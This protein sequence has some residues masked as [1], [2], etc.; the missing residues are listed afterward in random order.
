[1]AFMKLVR[2]LFPLVFALP[3]FAGTAFAPDAPAAADW[4]EIL[5]NRLP[6]LGH[7]NWIVIADS[8]YPEQ[9]DPGIQTVYSDADQTQVVEYTLRL[10]AHAPHVAPTVFLDQELDFLPESDAPGITNYRE[11]LHSIIGDRQLMKQPHE[12]IMAELGQ[13]SKQFSVLI[14][15]TRSILPYTTVFL[16]LDCAYWPADAE[17]RLR[18]TMNESKKH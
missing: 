10:L 3:L 8:A 12:Q 4:K 2:I 13:V 7:R 6:L 5:A 15:K 11:T 9:S 18:K 1:M 17:A 16:R 14:I